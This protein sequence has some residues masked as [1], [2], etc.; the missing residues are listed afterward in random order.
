MSIQSEQE[1]E[2]TCSKLQKLEQRYR[3]ICDHPDHTYIEQL[4]LQSLRRMINQM[5][6]EIALF[7]AR[8]HH[9][10]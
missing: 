5:R 4:T 1:Y 3:E 6:E 2:V 10:Q 7:K 8:L 9:P